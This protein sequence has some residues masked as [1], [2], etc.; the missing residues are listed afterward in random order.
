MKK[1]SAFQLRSGNKPSPAKLS[2]VSPMK[3]DKERERFEKH[4][5]EEA[6]KT[7]AYK[8][9]KAKKDRDDANQRAANEYYLRTGIEVDKHATD[10]EAKRLYNKM[11]GNE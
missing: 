2:G 1:E 6:K 3:N 11:V 4:R 7:K 5:K 9:E 8:I 10:P